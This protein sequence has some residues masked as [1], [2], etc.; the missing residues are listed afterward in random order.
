MCWMA[1]QM[2]LQRWLAAAS[3]TR[4]QKMDVSQAKKLVGAKAVRA[5]FS[6]WE[7]LQQSVVDPFRRLEVF[8][9]SVA[10]ALAFTVCEQKVLYKRDP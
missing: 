8:Q 5:W 6:S 1:V 10:E 3:D 7:A 9:A 4:A 2:P